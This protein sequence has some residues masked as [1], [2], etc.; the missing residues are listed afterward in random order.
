MVPSG[1]FLFLRLKL[2]L[3]G[4]KFNDILEIQQKLE[5]AL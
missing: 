4:K 2:K 1:F 3:K 5:E